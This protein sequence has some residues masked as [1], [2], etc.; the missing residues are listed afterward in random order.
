MSESQWKSVSKDFVSYLVSALREDILNDVYDNTEKIR[1]QN[2]LF[3]L[4]K[5]ADSYEKQRDIIT[6]FPTL[7]EEYFKNCHYMARVDKH[8]SREVAY[9]RALYDQKIHELDTGQITELLSFLTKSAARNNTIVIVTS[10]HGEEFMEHGYLGHNTL[11][12]P[13]TRVVFIMA[14]PGILER[15]ISDYVQSADITPTVLELLGI[16]HKYAFQ[17]LS[18]MPAFSGKRIQKR[19]LIADSTDF[20]KKTL[21]LGKWKLFLDTKSDERIPT[22]LYDVEADPME[23]RNLLFTHFQF[24]KEILAQYEKEESAWLK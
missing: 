11:Y 21:R 14:V 6:N 13:N 19:L 23:T 1:Y 15:T 20:S 10:D 24:A 8:N 5:Y 22:E 12:N 2:L 18:L 16:R 9:L 3:D 7:F 4:E 17:G